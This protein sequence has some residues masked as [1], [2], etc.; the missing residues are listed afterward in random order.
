VKLEKNY[1]QDTPSVKG[2]K[3]AR[4]GGEGG[5]KK[6][7]KEGGKRGRGGREEG[8]VGRKERR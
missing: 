2:M 4:H 3:E 5:G 6:R 7:R 1:E 8:K